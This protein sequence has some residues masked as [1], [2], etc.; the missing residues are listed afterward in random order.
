MQLVERALSIA[1]AKAVAG[2]PDALERGEDA[3][4]VLRRELVKS[5]KAG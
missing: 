5:A 3:R 2:L 1:L 4:K